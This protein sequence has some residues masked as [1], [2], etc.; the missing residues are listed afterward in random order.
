MMTMHQG[1][2][3]IAMVPSSPWLWGAYAG[4]MIVLIAATVHAARDARVFNL[5]I[6]HSN[7]A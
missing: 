6:P 2:F 3:S 4:I 5:I 7:E 1:I